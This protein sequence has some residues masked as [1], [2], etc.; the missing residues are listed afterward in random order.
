MGFLQKE[1]SPTERG[2]DTFFGYY[3]ACEADY[4]YH[5][6]NGGYPPNCLKPDGTLPTDLSNSTK[7]S[8]QPADPALNGTYNT[9]LFGIEAVR[10]IQSHNVS[11]PFYMYLAFMAVHDGCGNLEMGK[12]A[13]LATVQKYGNT[14]LDTY[15]VAGAMYTE[16]DEQI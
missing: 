13:P 4:W 3:S 5:G 9:R 2:F 16:M 11:K 14:K 6:G 15:K 10:L 7:Q 1:C 8:I 12:Q